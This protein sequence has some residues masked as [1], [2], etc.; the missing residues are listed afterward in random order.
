MRTIRKTYIW[1]K[2]NDWTLG[3]PVPKQLKTNEKNTP[4]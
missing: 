1:C 4:C 2:D 3:G